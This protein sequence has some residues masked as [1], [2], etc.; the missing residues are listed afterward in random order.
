M[1]LP[2]IRSLEINLRRMN[3]ETKNYGRDCAADV[4]TS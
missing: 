1:E 2:L 4:T 3:Y